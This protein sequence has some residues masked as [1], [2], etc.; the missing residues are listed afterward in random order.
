M[1][2]QLPNA[3]RDLLMLAPSSIF[4][5]VFRV[6]IFSLPARSTMNI[7]EVIFYPFCLIT[8]TPICMMACDL[9]LYWL[10]KVAL[11]LLFCSPMAI[12]S[13]ISYSVLI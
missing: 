3:R 9:E 5:A 10:P 6:W 8:S 12:I 13:L 2:I 11:E 7:L 4:L 1:L